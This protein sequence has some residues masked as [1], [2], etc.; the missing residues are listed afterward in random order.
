VLLTQP[1]NR[2]L[3]KSNHDQASPLHLSFGSIWSET[4]S[5]EVLAKAVFLFIFFPGMRHERSY[6]ENYTPSRPLWEVKSH[7]AW[8]VVRWVTTCEA[9]VLF[10]LFCTCTFALF[11]KSFVVPTYLLLY[12]GTSF[13]NKLFFCFSPMILLIS[14]STSML[15]SSRHRAWFVEEVQDF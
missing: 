4:S 5:P 13:C 14:I 11:F 12:P 1:I 2:N 8:S 7:L 10:V 15:V 3:R 9:R 6:N